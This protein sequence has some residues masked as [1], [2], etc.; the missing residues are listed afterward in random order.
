[1]SRSEPSRAAAAVVV[2]FDAAYRRLA[3]RLERNVRLAVRAPRPVIEEACQTAWIRLL[4]ADPPVARDAALGWL[5]TTAAREAV[6]AARAGRRERPLGDCLGE[7]IELPARA[8]GPERVAELR[9]QL[10][11]I[12]RLPVRQRQIMWLRSLGYGYEEIV[13]LTGDSYRTVER[14]LVRARQTLRQRAAG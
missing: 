9:E 5:T 11:E 7:V 6:R 13:A 8:P 1:M 14:Q 12:R 10:A 2:D 3:P 4:T